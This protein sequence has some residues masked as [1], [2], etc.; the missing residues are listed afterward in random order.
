MFC[1]LLSHKLANWSWRAVSKYSPKLQVFPSFLSSAMYSATPSVPCCTRLKNLNRSAI[2]T[3]QFSLLHLYSVQS[4][5]CLVVER[6]CSSDKSESDVGLASVFNFTKASRPILFK[7]EL[8][9][10]H[11]GP[12][13]P[14]SENRNVFWL[15]IV[16]ALH[17]G[18][19]YLQRYRGSHSVPYQPRRH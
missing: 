14:C 19:E 11:R 16:Y 13:S 18:I 3:V 10:V 17:V 2:S 6:I 8:S 12:D 9:F 4:A 5:G 7:K 15:V 1:D